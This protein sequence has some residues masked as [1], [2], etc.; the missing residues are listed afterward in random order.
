[1]KGN[2]KKMKGKR[3]DMERV[4]KGNKKGNDKEMT[5]K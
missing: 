3:K 2:G 1:M 5:R 4:E